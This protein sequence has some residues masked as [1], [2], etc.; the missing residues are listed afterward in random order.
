[1]EW[2]HGVIRRQWSI[3]AEPSWNKRLDFATEWTIR[4][5][6]P[7]FLGYSIFEASSRGKY[8]GNVEDSQEN[9][10]KRIQKAAPSFGEDIIEAQK[11]ALATHIAPFYEGPLGIDMLSDNEGNIN[12]CVEINLRLTMGHLSL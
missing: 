5:G 3:I 9:L 7:E 12:S 11:M 8:H 1:M 4:S 10:L 2:A 6:K